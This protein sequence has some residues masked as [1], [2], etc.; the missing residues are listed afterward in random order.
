[1][2]AIIWTTN[3]ENE[4]KQMVARGCNI[5]YIA[6]SFN[7]STQAVK[8][9]LK[10]LGLKTRGQIENEERKKQARMVLQEMPKDTESNKRPTIRDICE[11]YRQKYK[12]GDSIRIGGKRCRVVEVCQ[13]FMVVAARY[14]ITVRYVDLYVEDAK[15]H[16]GLAA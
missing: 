11:Y 1:M 8:N 10:K 4:L 2:P 14:R 12:V 13:Y 15:R 9:K 3:M 5:E 16:E 7:I 6:E